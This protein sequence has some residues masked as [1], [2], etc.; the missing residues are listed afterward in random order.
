LAENQ[1][2]VDRNLKQFKPNKGAGKGTL[3]PIPKGIPRVERSDDRPKVDQKKFKQNL[4][5]ACEEGQ[6]RAPSR[7]NW[8]KAGHRGDSKRSVETLKPKVDTKESLDGRAKPNLDS[9]KRSLDGV[10][11]QVDSRRSVDKPQVD[12]RRSVDKPQVDSRR[13]VDKPQ[14]D[15]RRSVDKP[16][17]GVSSQQSLD[18]IKP[19]VLC[20][21]GSLRSVDK[22]G[23]DSR[24]S[25][26]RPQLKPDTQQIPDQVRPKV[27]RW[28]DPSRRSVDMPNPD[29]WRNVGRPKLAPDT[30]QIPDQVRPKVDSRR[31]V[32]NPTNPAPTKTGP[33]ELRKAA[34]NPKPVT[35]TDYPTSNKSLP[36]NS[37]DLPIEIFLPSQKKPT[38]FSPETSEQ[39][40]QPKIAPKG[41]D[42]SPMKGTPK[43]SKGDT[44]E[45]SK[46]SPNTAYK[47]NQTGAED[48]KLENYMRSNRNSLLVDSKRD[49]YQ[50]YNPTQIS[51]KSQAGLTP[52][53]QTKNLDRESSL[54][55][56]TINLDEFSS[57][58]FVK[59]QKTQEILEVNMTKDTSEAIKS[60]PWGTR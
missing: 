42:S 10:K 15:S 43:N 31:S 18:Q 48:Q 39:P 12:S 8:D 54:G 4:D 41:L 52:E 38:Q 56:D 30:Q 19:K 11:P 55:S 34:A 29:P 44:L 1:K 51:N 45:Y 59:K 9:S 33:L 35:N 3:N 28:V 27:I 26:E 5:K 37:R 24:S 50:P 32:Q 58:R 25:V 36:K 13:S 20:W 22:L 40:K 17:S 53:S 2:F 46:L 23:P 47:T 6:P 16:T 57:E 49:M 7:R 21:T 14:V 60:K